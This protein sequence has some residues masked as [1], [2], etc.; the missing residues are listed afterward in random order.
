MAGVLCSCWTSKALRDGGRGAPSPPAK[1][2]ASRKPR[3]QG[4]SQ[5]GLTCPGPGCRTVWPSP[6][7]GEQLDRPVTPA[8]TAG[9]PSVQVEG[10]AGVA[11]WRRRS[12]AGLELSD[13]GTR[14]VSRGPWAVSQQGHLCCGHTFLPSRPAL[15]ADL[16]AP[17]PGQRLTGR[18]RPWAGHTRARTHA[19]RQHTCTHVHTCTY[20]YMHTGAH[21]CTHGTHAHTHVHAHRCTHVHTRT[22]KHMHTHG[23]VHATAV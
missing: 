7:Q 8:G 9:G 12:S 18:N 22:C 16:P 17:P 3:L 14:V 23:N 6:R 1:R 21:T 20:T 11:S 13:P 4:R 2:G 5:G 15:P 19:H 10:R